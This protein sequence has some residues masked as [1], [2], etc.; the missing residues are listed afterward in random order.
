MAGSD[1]C[2]WGWASGN[3]PSTAPVDRSTSDVDSM[4]RGPEEAACG[5]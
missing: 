2:N 1:G 3:A 4:S 5:T